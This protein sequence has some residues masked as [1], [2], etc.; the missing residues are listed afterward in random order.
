MEN[1][2]ISYHW[3]PATNRGRHLMSLAL[4]LA[5]VWLALHAN[6]AILAV[7]AFLFGLA[8]IAVQLDQLTTVDQ[9]AGKVCRGISLW[10]LP[11]R[12]TVWPLREFSGVGVYRVPAGSPQAPA[13]L[14][15]VGLQRTNGTIVAVRCFYSLRSQPCP[16]AEDFE[17]QLASAVRNPEVA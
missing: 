17:R 14:V 8:S 6:S 10:G 2:C 12:K 7:L 3:H 1:Y 5:C 11:L 9:K 16:A 13:D 15:H 4:L